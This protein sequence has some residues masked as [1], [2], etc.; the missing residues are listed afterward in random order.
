MLRRMAGL[1]SVENRIWMLVGAG[2]AAGV[3]VVLL[4]QWREA[5]LDA[6]REDAFAAHTQ[7]QQL[8]WD[9]AQ[10]VDHQLVALTS[11]AFSRQDD[12][13]SRESLEDYM[14]GSDALH[15]MQQA[16]EDLVVRRGLDEAYRPLGDWL[17]EWRNQTEQMLDLRAE[18]LLALK[19]AGNRVAL[20][21][22]RSADLVERVEDLGVVCDL[23]AATAR[24]QVQRAAASGAPSAAATRRLEDSAI[25]AAAVQDLRADALDCR[26]L[27]ARLATAE[28]PR[29][30]GQLQGELLRCA[31]ETIPA[32][33]AAVRRCAGST[34]AYDASLDDIDDS[35]LRLLTVV[36]GEEAPQVQPRGLLGWHSEALRL[37]LA[38]HAL[39]PEIHEGAHAMAASLDALNA[40]LAADSRARLE[41]LESQTQL[42]ARIVLAVVVLLGAA[43]LTVARRISA[44][45]ARI[46]QGEAAAQ[47]RLAASEA[48]FA[49]MATI[50]SDW[51]WELDAAGRF[52]YVSAYGPDLLGQPEAGLLGRRFTDILPEYERERMAAI[53]RQ[54]LD[55]SGG[56]ADVEHWIESADGRELCLLGN[57]RPITDGAGRVMGFRGAS[58]DI[59]EQVLT[60]EAYRSAKEEAEQANRHLELAAARANDMAIEA[61]AA[62]AAKSEFLATMSHEIRTPINGIIGMNALLLESALDA[63]QR[64]YAAAVSSSADTLLSLI[65]DILDYS[66]IEAGKVEL[67]I[68]PVDV[69][70]IVDDV[71][72][73]L[74]LR[75]EEKGLRLTGC[76]ASD[77]PAAVAGDPTRLR[78]VLINLVGNAIKFT[79]AG[80]IEVHA[81]V[82]RRD[83]AADVL[84][85]AV[86]DTGIGIPR[87][88]I[89]KLFEAFAQADGSTTRRFG[90]TGLGLSISRRLVQLMGGSIEVD[91]EVGAGSTFRF[92]T[93]TSPVTIADDLAA[94][95]ARHEQRRQALARLDAAIVGGAEDDAGILAQHLRHLGLAVTLFPRLDDLPGAADTDDAPT[96]RLLFVFADGDGDD[97]IAFCR[98]RRPDARAVLVGDRDA[99]RR[100]GTGAPALATPLRH[101]PI[102]E[103]I[104]QM[105]GFGSGLPAPAGDGG[106]DAELAGLRILLVDDNAINRK[107]ALGALKRW[108]LTADTAADGGEALERW[109]AGDYQVILMDCMMPGV[110]G[111]EATRRIRRAE[112]GGRVTIIAMTANAQ[113]GDRE[114]CLA[115]GMDDYVAKPLKRDLLRAAL[116]R[117]VR[118]ESPAGSTSPV[119]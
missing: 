89:R 115:A 49:D 31:A 78:Q 58:K 43:Y 103:L 68:L 96:P 82:L 4:F 91:S 81:G 24:R 117:A 3:L 119:A 59:T 95:N 65:N 18:A 40:A 46:R 52:T 94:I 90:G 6:Q 29:V 41:A 33:L 21:G 69:R 102:A 101:R 51:L 98:R 87:H 63:E 114:S 13:L 106:D 12:A 88:K 8:E 71:L 28:D 47:S 37:E 67:E 107:V 25:L 111:Y 48:R 45:I 22:D 30:A 39:L 26:S 108:G 50:S 60:R 84:S 118:K 70:A 17:G 42:L 93:A 32:R 113:E 35:A 74:H 92:T 79:S 23:L 55:G 80:V 83:A 62:N 100:M 64:E 38:M 110:D 36:V 109:R 85:F 97:A 16:I 99:R 14:S 20:A 44:S 61:Q 105:D 53:L 34:T 19:R 15:P 2:L 11:L 75:A 86:R 56:F 1:A 116:Q 54:A 5:R 73:L 76:V 112:T 104:E 72:D 7:A 10:N 9:L 27:V 57:G 77:V 66:K